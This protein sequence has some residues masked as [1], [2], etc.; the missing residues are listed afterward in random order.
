M[1]KEELEKACVFVKKI[2]SCNSPVGEI[3]LTEYDSVSLQCSTGDDVCVGDRIRIEKGRKYSIGTEGVVVRVCE[4]QY[5]GTF[6]S[7]LTGREILDNPSL[8]VQLADETTIWVVGE[9]CLNLSR[10]ER[11]IDGKVY[12][13]GQY[14]SDFG[15][16]SDAGFWYLDEKKRPVL[17]D[18][19]F[20]DHGMSIYEN[21]FTETEDEYVMILDDW[22]SDTYPFLVIKKEI[23]SGNAVIYHRNGCDKRF[24]DMWD[25]EGTGLGDSIKE[26]KEYLA[27]KE[28][29]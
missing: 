4:N 23:K 27:K 25:A 13:K 15:Y 6:R 11:S 19:I 3:K 20:A 16:I 18:G 29:A 10:L 22:R 28:V 9:N 26:Y 8:K 5:A 2:H 14:P 17:V 7:A 24:T 1:K 21:Y 12:R